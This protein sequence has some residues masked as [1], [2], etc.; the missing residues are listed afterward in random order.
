MTRF[1]NYLFKFIVMKSKEKKDFDSL[2][3][4]L[5]VLSKE[6]MKVL[7]GGKARLRFT[8]RWTQRCSDSIP[9]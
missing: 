3:R 2:K 5:Q 1:F 8:N 9:Q 6:E 7:K 4:D